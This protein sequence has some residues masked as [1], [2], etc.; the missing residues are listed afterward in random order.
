MEDKVLV[1]TSPTLRMFKTEIDRDDL[2]RFFSC[3]KAYSL[4]EDEDVILSN[5][6]LSKAL[7]AK[8]EKSEHKL[9]QARILHR[10][11][12]GQNLSEPE[13]DYHSS[14][15]Q[16]KLNFNSSFTRASL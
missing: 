12:S 13:K 16:G 15:A 11:N 7:N 14:W 4:E 2:R 1:G 9:I 5:G 10:I 8:R 6:D 3:I